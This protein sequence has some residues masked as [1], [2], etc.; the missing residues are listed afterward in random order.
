MSDNREIIERNQATALASNAAL[1]NQTDDEDEISNV[2]AVEVIREFGTHHL[3]DRVHKA[4]K[5][6]LEEAN[7]RLEGIILEKTELLKR[8][9]NERETDGVQLYSL[10]Q[11]LARVQMSLESAHQ[12]FNGIVD[13]RL[14][15]EEKHNELSASN[16][17]K[18]TL[19]EEHNQQHSKYANE[20][21]ALTEAI[22]QVEKYNEDVK[23]EIAVTRRAAY[24]TEQSIQ[25]LEKNKQ[26]QDTYA[27]N[28]TKQ[29]KTLQQQ[30]A[31]YSGQL[32]TQQKETEEAASVLLE[33]AKELDLIANE[34]KQLMMQWKAALSGLSRR[35]EALAQASET[36]QAAESAV[37]DYDVEIDGVKRQIQKEQERHESLSGMRDRLE[38]DLIWVEENLSKMVIERD[39]LQE[40]YTLMKKSLS[41]TDTDNKKLDSIAKQLASEEE[42]ILQSIQ[43]VTQ[44]RQSI[45][46]EIQLVISTKT[47]I[48][49]AVENLLKEQL[50]VIK[51]IHTV[52][53]EENSIKNEIART[54]VDG[55][56]A[57]T[58]NDQ[59]KGQV[60][61]VSRVLAE[62]ESIISKYQLEIRQRN[63][64]IEKKMYRVDRLNK[65][66][67]KMVENVGGEENLGPLENTIR[68]LKKEIESLNDDCKELERDWLRKQTDLVTITTASEKFN[69]ENNELQA[70]LTIL[71]QQQLRLNK[72]HR[73][74][75]SEVK[76][77]NQT[78]ADLQKDIQKLNAIINDNHDQEGQLQHANFILEKECIDELKALEHD[79]VSMQASIADVKSAKAQLLDE[80]MD[81]E[82]QSSL[83]EKKIQLEKETKEALD[84][85][86][87]QQETKNMEKEIR[88]MSLRLDALKREQ[89][90]LVTEMEKAIH[91]RSVIATRYNSKPNQSDTSSSLLSSSDSKHKESTLN[92]AT[93]KKKIVVLKRELETINEQIAKNIMNIEEKKALLSEMSTDLDDTTNSLGLAEETC[94]MLQSTINDLL[95]QKQING[96]RIAYKQKY[97]KLVRE[98]SSKEVIVFGQ[99][100]QV[101]RKLLVSSQALDNLRDLLTDLSGSYPHL[102]DVLAR[103][104]NMTDSGISLALPT[105]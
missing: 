60:E 51:K 73:H 98:S 49:K 81:M 19:I 99:A 31:M 11:Q 97:L 84:P 27:D 36:L 90:R 63:D 59:L 71:T 17:E 16:V 102:Q 70:R 72:D 101:E 94:Q 91:K 37:H 35:D 104:Q 69:E 54:K 29:I 4:F 42:T 46:E 33:T 93:I 28:L 74:L 13:V 86:I 80:I 83:W 48:S 25:E 26:V 77:A 56:N 21:K 55:F 14:K 64:E 15:Y 43:V 61:S 20:L 7:K 6:Q 88:R 2:D 58:L 76:V 10:Q 89:E 50:K 68:N 39:Q 32:G 12:E 103:V 9:S 18:K 79:C 78:H 52:E 100:L 57:M 66:Y 96:E 47:N 38:N 87:G 30:I 40:R 44:E 67:E 23:S 1:G 22:R 62:K 3:M 75:K 5:D 45:D 82:R 41:Q 65:K 24:K 95:Y 8:L 34:K 105:Q 92:R 53:N 85:T